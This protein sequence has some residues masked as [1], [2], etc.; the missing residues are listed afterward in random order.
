MSQTNNQNVFSKVFSQDNSSD[1]TYNGWKNYET[2]NFK[3]WIDNNQTLHNIV[4]N[5]VKDMVNKKYQLIW[6]E[7]VADEI[8]GH[9]D[10]CPDLKKSDRDK[11]DFEEIL[12]AMLEDMGC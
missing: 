7:N 11:I 5:G 9:P 12:E 6:L 1:N 3:L 4:N 10:L 8:V 2:W